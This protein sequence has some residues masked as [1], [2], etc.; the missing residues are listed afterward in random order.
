MAITYIPFVFP[1]LPQVR[2]AFQ[3]RVGGYSHGAY[4]GGNLSFVTKD[5]RKAVEANR[6]DLHQ[7]LGLEHIAELSQ[8]HGDIFH[9]EPA[10]VGIAQA[11][12][13]E[14]DGFATSSARMGLMIKTADCQPILLAHSSGTCVA[15]LHVGWRGN[16]INF[17]ATAVQAFCRHYEVQASEILAV[18]GPSLGP[19]MAEFVNFTA[20]WNDSFSPWYDAKARTMDLWGLTRFQL[21]QAGLLPAHIYGVDLCTQTMH[22][23][24]FSYRQEKESGRQGSVIWIDAAVQAL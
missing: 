1:G 2:C 3:T 5:E 18:R 11:P 16:R 15:A 24:F 9:F 6:A 17:P 8:V 13:L 4:G 20:E 12:S 19:R 21:E 23:H 10:P 7:V 22:E 14:G